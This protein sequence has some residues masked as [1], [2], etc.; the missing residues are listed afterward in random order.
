MRSLP[1]PVVA[2]T[3]ALLIVLAFA[4]YI[5]SYTGSVRYHLDSISS[6]QKWPR[7]PSGFRDYF[8]FRTILWYMHGR[9]SPPQVFEEIKKHQGALIDLGYFE[10]RD[11]A[12]KRRILDVK[13]I[14]EFNAMLTNATFKRLSTWTM[15]SGMTSVIRVTGDRGD[16]LL[17]E[18]AVT[19]FDSKA[20]K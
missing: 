1:K 3:F 19:N 6:L 9:P 7:G 5:H 16:M 17:F 10:T 20:S 13:G 12:L 11:F 8:R 2:S 4:F 15:P 14:S 18:S